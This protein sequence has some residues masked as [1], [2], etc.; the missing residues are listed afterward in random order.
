MKVNG[1]PLLGG[2][3]QARQEETEGTNQEAPVRKVGRG[4][5]G[6]GEEVQCPALRACLT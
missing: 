5:G 4:W 6:G 1:N 3:T 2:E